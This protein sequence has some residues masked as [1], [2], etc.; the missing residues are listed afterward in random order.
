MGLREIK[1]ERTRRTIQ[2]VAMRLFASQGY[3]ATSVEQIAAAAEISPPTFYRFYRDKEDIVL[4]L[5]LAPILDAAEEQY[6]QGESMSCLVQALFD[7]L[8]Q[9]HHEHRGYLLTR[10]RLIQN[11]PDLRA[12]LQ[13]Q[14]QDHLELALKKVAERRK[15]SIASRDLRVVLAVVIAAGCESVDYWVMNH[16]KPNLSELLNQAL[17]LIEPTLKLFDRTSASQTTGRTETPSVK[18]TKAK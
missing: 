2:E 13:L 12:R 18:R 8:A 5:D 7:A 17:R 6:P 16:G 1:K 9:H 15:T 11:E 14:R 10:Y 4:T 3:G